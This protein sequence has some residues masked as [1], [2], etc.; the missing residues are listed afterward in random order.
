MA[1]GSPEEI[2]F[3]QADRLRFADGGLRGGLS[4]Y[5]ADDASEHGILEDRHSGADPFQPEAA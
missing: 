4:G 1:R 2:E 3:R 5:M